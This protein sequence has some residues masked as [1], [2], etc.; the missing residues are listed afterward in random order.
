M[1]NDMKRAGVI[2]DEQGAQRLVGTLKEV[3]SAAKENY[4]SF[5]LASSQWD[6][7]TKT[8]QK[9]ADRLTF[10]S[11]RYSIQSDK[12]RI[13]TE[14]HK[15]LLEAENK[16]V[17][18]I[19]DKEAQLKG[20]QATLNKYG[21]DL[22]SVR[23][24]IDAGTASLKDMSDKLS[25][26]GDALTN[27]GKKMA[28]FS[29]AYAAASGVS[30]KSAMDFEKAFTGVKKTVDG[31]PDQLKE[32][33]LGI[34]D[35]AKQ[36][37]T[38]A[39]SIAG[40]AETAGQLGIKTEDILMFTE[41]MIKLGETTNL[42][43]EEGANAIARFTNVTGMSVSNTDRLVSSLVALGNNSATTEA[44]IM[45][46]ASRLAGAGSQAKL[47]EAQILGISASLSSVGIEAEAGGSAFSKLLS[48]MQIA[49]ELGGDD[50]EAFARVA[51]MTGQEFKTAFQ[52]NA[53]NA[54]L[55]FIDGLANAEEQGTSAI[56]M[57]D[58][59]GIKEVR[60][61]DALLKA[62]GANDLFSSSLEMSQSAW[63]E[64]T[65]LTN[66]YANI[67][68][69]T[70]A[71]WEI[72][73]NSL[74]DLAIT[75]GNILLPSIN[76]MLENLQGLATW[77]SNLDPAIQKTIVGFAGII[78]AFSPILIFLGKIIT[79]I[80]TII[81]LVAKIMPILKP[82]FIAIKG[83][84]AAVAAALA[85]PVAA[86][87]AI[88][89]AIA[90]VVAIVVL[91]WDAIASYTKK[92]AESMSKVFDDFG[93]W[94]NE[95]VTGIV[96]WF[97]N[98]FESMASWFQGLFTTIQ[99]NIELFIASISEKFS[100]F[101]QFISDFMTQLIETVIANVSEFI[102]SLLILLNG[103][104]DFLKNV[105]IL[106]V[107]LV[108]MLLE[109]L[110]NM[111][112]P[113][114]DTLIVGF[115]N[116]KVF[117]AETVESIKTWFNQFIESVRSNFDS[118]IETVSTNIKS[119][120]DAV[121]ENFNNFMNAVKNILEIVKTTFTDIFTAIQLFVIGI[122]TNISTFIQSVANAFSMAWSSASQYV[123][124]NVLNPLVSFFSN[125]FSTISSIVNGVISSIIDGFKYAGDFIYR[126]FTNIRDS[127]ATLFSSIAGII[128]GPINGVISMMNGVIR[129]L[130][131]IK[132]PDWVPG[133]GGAGVNFG[134]I[135]YLQHGGN[136]V[137]GSAI[138][139]EAG[140][141]LLT[142]GGGNAQVTPLTSSGGA[143][144]HDLIDYEQ[145]ASVMRRV[146][147]GLK[148]EVADDGIAKLVDNRLLEVMQ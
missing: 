26:Q 53:A 12:V 124:T 126:T 145:F 57:L 83:G 144:Q 140:A 104:I 63:S 98:S 9:L 20:A 45:A 28:V 69:T 22:E 39:V 71:Q 146:F 142:V 38:A 136:L 100:I 43:A 42:S 24:E 109:S 51:G 1:P 65:A 108:A 107:A 135:A 102:S 119:F 139:G 127:I 120:I 48:N 17:N 134:E 31:T 7:N 2:F 52:D 122:F 21:K 5:R 116:F 19:R 30:V 117:I 121:T 4:Q 36:M 97:M 72:T 84:I 87:I 50:L 130:N 8:S 132:V 111:I 92:L 79:S 141:E 82:A 131:K 46:M 27:A 29:A 86:V 34:R 16:D 25:K 80:G 14:E 54:L 33:E 78:A 125:I 73:K 41:T 95:M 23:K 60:M 81:G 68:E 129:S 85:S 15:K 56:V 66:E 106:I 103:P 10:L 67:L 147:T 91:N 137:R 58:E 18:A 74:N 93:K 6:E 105:G 128:K 64:N 94:F 77:L 44:E 3:S 114:I 90:A 123:Q 35:M 59:M 76:S 61:R 143:A 75:V 96:N 101:K 133:I 32:V 37:P 89:A 88:G 113:F 70:S 13:L 11:D 112:S 148:F 62:A 49:T 99:A 115:T 110:W 47:T 138:V 55:A 40:V 118:F